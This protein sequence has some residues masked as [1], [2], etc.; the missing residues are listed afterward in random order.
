MGYSDVSWY[1]EG[2]QGW[3]EGHNFV[4]S[5]DYTYATRSIPDPISARDLRQK[6]RTD[7]MYVLVDIRDD[8]SRE[9]TG[10]IE[11]PELVLPLYR[12]HLDLQD[13]PTDKILVIYDIKAKQAPS[14]VR[15]LMKNGFYFSNLTYLEGGFTA[16]KRLELPTEN[17]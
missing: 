8:K 14:A 4:E 9:S 5:S 6:L 12:L 11:G 10:S 3:Q 2:L 13:L 15:F 1:R 16:W 17:P 7:D